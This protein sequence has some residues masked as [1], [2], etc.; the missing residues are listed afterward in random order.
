VDPEEGVEA[1]VPPR[2][3]YRD[4]P[5]RHVAHPRTAVALD[6][7]ARDV[8]LRDLGHQ[9]EREL[10]LLPVLVD[11]RD[12]LGV[13]ERPNPVPDLALLVREKVVQN[14]VVGPQRP[15]NVGD[16][17]QLLLLRSLKTQGRPR[18]PCRPI[19]RAIIKIDKFVA[20]GRDAAGRGEERRGG[21]AFGD[22]ARRILGE[23]K[24]RTVFPLLIL[25]LVREKPQYGNSLIGQIR[26]LSG[27]VMSVS[28][29]TVYPLLRR[30][31]EKGYVVGEWERPRR[32]AGAS[33]GSRRAA[34]RS[35]P[36]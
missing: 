26:E 14:V 8:Q 3:L 21:G 25:H 16:H 4:E 10:G 13:R 11:D 20:E 28:P 31:E 2:H 32:R 7:P 19:I 1:P 22:A 30:L 34:R 29:N 35:T 17:G 9:L 33:T 5:G 36:R 23:V 24:S 15:G 18:A 6:G 12:D 27:G